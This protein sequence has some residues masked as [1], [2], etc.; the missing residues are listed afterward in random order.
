MTSEERRRLLK[1][2]MKQEFKNDIKKRKEI[3]EQMKVMRHTRKLNEAVTGITTGLTSDDSDD[4]IDKINQKT[5]L[6]EAKFEVSLDNNSAVNQEIE[7]LEKQAQ[8][9]KFSAEQLIKDMKRQM[10]LIE[11][12]E[13]P[14]TNKSTDEPPEKKLGDF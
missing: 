4:W 11:E 3:E 2:Q 6:N 5:A 10:G 13:T 8:A 1:E 14:E 7:N 12:E 9:E